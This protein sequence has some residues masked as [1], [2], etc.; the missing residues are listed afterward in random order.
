[1][2][3]AED[4]GGGAIAVVMINV[5]LSPARRMIR[6]VTLAMEIRKPYSHILI[7]GFAFTSN[8]LLCYA[9]SR[10]IPNMSG[11]HSVDRKRFCGYLCANTAPHND[12]IV[13]NMDNDDFGELPV[14]G[15]VAC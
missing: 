4:F 12:V 14:A 13:T 6:F 5:T 7:W 15:V 9:V 8:H 10:R 3:A 11:A 1:M 2:N